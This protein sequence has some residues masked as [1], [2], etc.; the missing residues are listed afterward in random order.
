M[1]TMYGYDKA[2]KT[3]AESFFPGAAVVNTFPF[4]RHL[5]GWF[6]GGG[7]HRF[8]AECRQAV[9][10]MQ[11]AP[12]DFVKQNMRNSINSQS[13]TA[14]FLETNQARGN[15]NEKIIQEVAAVGYADRLSIGN[16]LFGD[17]HESQSSGHEIDTIIGAHRLPEF[18]DRPSL[19]FVEAL[20]CKVLRWRLVA[21]LGVAHATRCSNIYEGYFIPGGATVIGNMW[22]MTRDESVYPEPERFNPEHFFTPGENLNDDNLTFAFGSIFMPFYHVHAADV[23]FSF[24]RRICVGNTL[25]LGIHAADATVWATIVS[26]L[27]MFNIAKA[28]DAAGTVIDIDPVYSDGFISHPKPFQCVITPRSEAAKTLVEATAENVPE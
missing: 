27:S 24:G 22:A 1:S 5:P 12:F 4:L 14:K 13:I 15:S 18:E 7:F 11:H 10:E 16:L 28:Q 2:V 3:L 23:F 20:Y 8:A 6:P 26:V 9:Q 19:P 17:G 25:I 21:P